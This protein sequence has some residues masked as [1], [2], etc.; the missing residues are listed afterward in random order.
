MI[1]LLLL[2]LFLSVSA[3][4]QFEA[5][6]HAVHADATQPNHH[7]AVT[8]LQSGQVETPACQV[9]IVGTLTVVTVEVRVENDF[10]PSVDY[11]LPP[12]C[13]PPALLS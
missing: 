6:H 2:G 12:S 13:G 1:A 3:M 9:A 4:A 7:C 5:L 8:L 10:V 11:S